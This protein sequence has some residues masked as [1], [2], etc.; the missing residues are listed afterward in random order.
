MQRRA[1]VLG[2]FVL[3]VAAALPAGA[4]DKITLFGKTYS[5]A[6][7]SRGQTYKNGLKVTLPAEGNKKCGLFFE[8]G[9]DPTQDRLWFACPITANADIVGDHLYA[10]KGADAN[11]MF[12][13][14]GA[15]LEQFFGG[16]SNLWRGGRPINVMLVNRENTGAGVDR[17]VLV[18]HFQD[19]DSYRL[20]DLDKMT[21]I[22]GD[23]DEGKASDSVFNRPR[24]SQSPDEADPNLPDGAFNAFA[25][26][27]NN[28]VVV[29]GGNEGRVGAEIG[30]WDVKKDAAFPVLSNITSITENATV[31][32]PTA[33][34]DGA[35]LEPSA[36]A[37]F[38]VDA[39]DPNSAEYWFI[40]TNG[41]DGDTDLAG[42]NL[43][44]RARFIFPADLTKEAPNG[45]KVELLGI[46][47]LKGK[48][49]H[50]SDG[51]VYGLAIG[52][53]VAPGLR[54]IYMADW[55]GNLYTLTPQ[56]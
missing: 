38:A 44:V 32:L 34:A 26:G 46:E 19:I 16:A 22:L 35:N 15:E 21:G 31:K 33:D 52:R 1:L 13:A 48:P 49:V 17:N 4:Q 14:A 12:T 20:F 51:G 6:K 27:P 54:R 3:A 37:R 55:A 8:Q 11:G 43:L 24:K 36:L 50:A 23:N 28:T 9:A 41:L 53:E 40:H 42:S 18:L 56:P 7:E 29:I 30:V 5:I 2:V 47:E 39:A 10:L 25:P 45:I